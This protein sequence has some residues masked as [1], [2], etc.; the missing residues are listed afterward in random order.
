M[1]IWFKITLTT[2]LI[3]IVMMFIDTPVKQA[4]GEKKFEYYNLIGGALVLFSITS[5]LLLFILGVIWG[6]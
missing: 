6:V 1:D 2:A 4:V 3:A 5:G